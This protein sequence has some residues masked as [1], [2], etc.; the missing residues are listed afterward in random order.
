MYWHLEDWMRTSLCEC[1]SDVVWKQNDKVQWV[2]IRYVQCA[3]ILLYCTGIPRLMGLLGFRSNE[4]LLSV[5]VIIDHRLCYV[6]VDCAYF[7]KASDKVPHNLLPYELQLR[8]SVVSGIKS[9][10]CVRK[11]RVKLN[12]RV[13][14]TVGR[15]SK[16]CTS[17]NHFGPN[18][19][20]NLHWWS[21]RSLQ[22][23]C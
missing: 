12:G 17:R 10:L 4:W 16:W 13:L 7:E 23:I 20:Y 21:T 3:I 15:C 19:I 2:T 14:L 18:F 11:Q 9:F 8:E 22:A 5:I 1:S 6:Y